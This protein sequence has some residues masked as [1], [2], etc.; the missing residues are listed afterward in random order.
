MTTS[1]SPSPIEPISADST[2]LL[3]KS[4]RRALVDRRE[5]VAIGDYEFRFQKRGETFEDDGDV[6]QALDSG[7]FAKFP[8]K[9]GDAVLP[10]KWL[11]LGSTDDMDTLVEPYLPKTQKDRDMLQ[12]GIGFNAAMKSVAN[13][14][15]TSVH[16]RPTPFDA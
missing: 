2:A 3:M 13:E 16:R 6:M 7:V 5:V 15:R 9:K 12:V 14:N 1:N 4:L 10:G 11:H 8:V